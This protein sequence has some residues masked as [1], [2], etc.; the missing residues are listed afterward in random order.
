[1]A[2]HELE[3]AGTV[4]VRR[5]VL[6]G[7]LLAVAAT[8][9]ATLAT[10]GLDGRTA[11]AALALALT[12]LT[13]AGVLLG[14][15]TTRTGEVVLL[16]LVIVLLT[17]SYAAVAVTVGDDP[18]RLVALQY[19]EFRAV[20]MIML[21]AFYVLR[22]RRALL[23]VAIVLAL[24][25]AIQGA[26]TGFALPSPELRQGLIGG[27]AALLGLAVVLSSLTL[28][29]VWSGEGR[30]RLGAELQ[31]RRR[32][33][34]MAAHDL[35]SPLGAASGLVRTVLERPGIDAGTQTQLLE[36][37]VATIDRV[38]GLTGDL[39]RDT[40]VGP[41]EVA[42]RVAVHDL[43]EGAVAQS[44]CA[45]S[46]VELS[47]PEAIVEV[48]ADSLQR[49]LVNLLDNAAKHGAPPVELSATVGGDHLT[50]VVSDAGP[51]L[52]AEVAA[53]PFAAFT[54]GDG[55]VE[56]L[57]LGL[58]IVAQVVSDA[59]GTVRVLPDGPGLTVSLRV[60]CPPGGS[61][62]RQDLVDVDA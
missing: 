25:V 57:G 38:L 37:A 15:V 22:P 6:V 13:L 47:A 24:L 59:G 7:L 27:F 8:N 9:A 45:R 44:R 19:R 54:R 39:L 41:R 14:R 26:T 30:E 55:P 35:S 58:H 60:P 18:A 3:L 23:H 56:G 31:D 12:L 4:R 10:V 36:R 53:D 61:A 5:A 32:L 34:A 50:I 48:A 16:W 21:L 29:T 46:D 17:A 20:V 11:A 33:Q 42:R 2:G 40:G 49:A 51:G 62:E 28:S 52:P 43:L 1:M